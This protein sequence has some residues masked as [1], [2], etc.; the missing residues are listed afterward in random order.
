MNNLGGKRIAGAQEKKTWFAYSLCLYFSS[1]NQLYYKNML[2][3]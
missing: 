2:N 3:K 1:S